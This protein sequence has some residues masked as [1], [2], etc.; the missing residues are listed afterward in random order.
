[1]PP[2][3]VLTGAGLLLEFVLWCPSASTVVQIIE[4]GGV[5]GRDDNLSH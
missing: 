5:Q 2:T 4:I 1:M 3:E